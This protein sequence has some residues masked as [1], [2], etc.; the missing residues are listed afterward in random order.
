M[1]FKA[2]LRPVG[3]TPVEGGVRF[4]VWAPAAQGV[5]VVI[6]R[7][8]GEHA[9]PLKP[10]DGGY[11]A[12]I[13]DGAGPGERY[14][15][16]LDGGDAFPDP[17]SRA[18]PDGVHGPSQVV[19]PDAFRWT[20]G[21]WHGV[22]LEEMVLYE[23]HVGTATP[24]G[25]FDGLVARLDDIRELGATAIELMPVA[26]FPGDRNWGYDGVFPWA[27]ARAYGGAEGLRRLVDEAHA[28]GLA[29]VIDAVYNHLGP[30]GNYLH[31]VTGGR[32][33]TD[34]HKTPWGDAVN[35][36]GPGAEAVR[37]FV[38]GNALHWAREYHV[39]GLR[40]DATHAILDDTERHVL[41]ELAD[42]LREE[43][44]VARHFVLFAEDERNERRVVG[45]IEEGGLGMHAVWADDFHHQVRALTAGDRDAYFG[46]YAGT[47]ED[48]AL[49]LRK[50]WLYEGQHSPNHG[51]PRGTPA[52]GIAPP[53]F[54]HAIQNHDQV[55]NRALGERLHHQ[56]PLP[57]YRAASALLL[58]SPYTP[59]L[60]M[61]Q[62]WHASSPF[63]YFTDHPEELGMRVTEGR[64]EEF[65]RFRSFSD[66]EARGRIPDPQSPETFQRSKLDWGERA[67]QPHAGILALYRELLAL[68]RGHPALR[69]RDRASF[70]VA[71]VCEGVLALRR[72][73]EKDAALLLVASFGGAARVDLN[74]A[75]E[76]RPPGGKGWKVGLWTEEARFGG[77]GAG[78]A[79]NEKGVLESPGPGALVLRT[80]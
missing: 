66:P 12:A 34:R 36:D 52:D 9:L 74:A 38:V 18:Q 31:A 37:G 75:F 40:L 1:R 19:D 63:L 47:V 6:H 11:F 71:C 13:I 8:D 41:A 29:V 54:V 48:L 76:T 60:W 3:A 14:T 10:E 23:V 7:P 2:D 51:A 67:R 79:L 32:F 43:L 65:A 42:T 53:R 20:D 78:P 64:R 69:P 27:P 46:D 22:P 49:T 33:F 30:E 21:G 58:L 62:E 45:E 28:R 57:V 17:A 15:F 50:G 56:V 70:A 25:T 24:E 4:R 26:D 61:G 39:D 35:Y 72:T 5:E 77:D 16:R 68:R 80:K 44:S 55:G 59:L 73:G